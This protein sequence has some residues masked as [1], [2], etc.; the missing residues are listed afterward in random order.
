MS[1]KT[2]TGYA[3]EWEAAEQA[4]GLPD[5]VRVCADNEN[6]YLVKTRRHTFKIQELATGKVEQLRK[7]SK[8]LGE[9]MLAESI[10]GRD[11]QPVSFGELEIR[12]WPGGTTTKLSLALSFIYEADNFLEESNG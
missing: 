5:Y 10:I 2:T 9:T 8:S 3:D 1:K 12:E 11:G 7:R 4:E 6:H